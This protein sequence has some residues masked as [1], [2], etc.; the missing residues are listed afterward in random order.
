MVKVQL[1]IAR[2]EDEMETGSELSFKLVHH[3]KDHIKITQFT[4][5]EVLSLN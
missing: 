1:A 3:K 5:C 2:S 4:K